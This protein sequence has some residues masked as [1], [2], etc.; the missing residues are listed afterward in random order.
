MNSLRASG[1]WFVLIVCL[2]AQPASGQP[3]TL[4]AADD[5]VSDYTFSSNGPAKAGCYRFL[6]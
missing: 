4:L 3:V 6:S 5:F 2:L 1:P